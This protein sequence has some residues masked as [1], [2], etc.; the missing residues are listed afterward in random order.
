[1]TNK[2]ANFI[3]DNRAFVLIA[4]VGILLF[5]LVGMGLLSV[6]FDFYSYLPQDLPSLKG[7]KILQDEFKSSTSIYLIVTGKTPVEV[8]QMIEGIESMPEVDETFWYSD[9][10]DVYI[11]TE[12]ASKEVRENFFSGDDTIVQVRLSTMDVGTSAQVE[13]IKK[14]L[15]DSSIRVVGDFLFVE[16]VEKLTEDAKTLMVMMAVIITLIFLGFALTQPAYS[17]LF[18]LVAGIAI[19]VNL[20]LSGAI[21]GEISFIASSVV[22]ALQIAVTLDYGVFL[23]HR[24][25][26]ERKENDNHVDAMKQAVAKTMVSLFSS[27]LTTAAGFLALMIMNYKMIGDMGIVMAQGVGIGFILSLTLLPCL[28]LLFEKPLS[29]LRHR[30]LIPSLAKVGQFVTKN[31]VIIVVVFLVITTVTAFGNFNLEVSYDMYEGI[32]L[33]ED[34]MTD[35]EFVEEKFG[36]GKQASIILTDMTLQERLELEEQVE[37]LDGIESVRG[38]FSL[39]ISHIPDSFI[40]KKVK[41]SLQ[42]ESRY[43]LTATL[44]EGN[45]DETYQIFENLQKMESE[46]DGKMIVT[47]TDVL[48]YDMARVSEN[49]L[50]KV[51]LVSV[52]AILLILLFT[53]RSFGQAFAVILAIEVAIWANI[54]YLFYTG[55]TNTFFA[56]FVSLSAIQLGATVDYCILLTTRFNEEKSK[57][58]IVEA[59]KRAVNGSGPAIITAALTL[60][61]ATFAI[62]ITSKIS[63]VQSMTALF[64]RGAI[65]SCLVVL[66]VLPALLL[67]V[68]KFKRS[69][70]RNKNA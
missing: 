27:G 56:S 36:S 62:S 24:Y 59:M 41:E 30:N 47:G 6:N 4:M 10:E 25:E 29:K 46:Q 28:I 22:A 58:P 65:I 11:P 13:A 66:F 20:G 31:R 51:T 26:E 21:R 8:Q 53:L 55:I 63:M 19:L 67:L 68:E 23:L 37:N 64:A 39:G 34:V 38:P 49:D 69:P 60:F 1:V 15:D 18:M 43:M 12:F 40:P 50:N 14:K 3:I 44:E 61:G 57:Y 45:T 35:L 54:S 32:K 48:Q 5:S 17:I 2:I 42:S 7:Q 52:I 33:S 16:E 9:L 70:R